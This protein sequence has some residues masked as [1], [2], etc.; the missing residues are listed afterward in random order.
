MACQRLTKGVKLNSYQL[1]QLREI[2]QDCSSTAEDKHTEKD[3]TKTMKATLI[4]SLRDPELNN[5][6]A[7]YNKAFTTES[8]ATAMNDAQKILTDNASN[9]IVSEILYIHISGILFEYT[10]KPVLAD[11]M[12]GIEI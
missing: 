7:I 8:P 2:F 12:T 6:L 11:V 4:Y 5:S 10:F 3:M 1:L 9:N